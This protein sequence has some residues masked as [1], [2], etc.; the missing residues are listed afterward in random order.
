MK[1]VDLFDKVRRAKLDFFQARPYPVQVIVY[2]LNYPDA[3]C[4]VFPE[5]LPDLENKNGLCSFW[6]Q[7]GYNIICIGIRSK[8]GDTPALL[9]HECYHAM[10]VIYEWFG[11]YH[12]NTNDEA[13]AYFLADLVRQ[14][15]DLLGFATRKT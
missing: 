10:N 14:T 11:A 5:A 4:K 12:D 13:G 7:D 2:D 1:E 15:S 9:A 6:R 3:L 8:T